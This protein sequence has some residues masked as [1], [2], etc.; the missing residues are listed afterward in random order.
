M[1]DCDTGKSQEGKAVL[2]L[3]TLEVAGFAAPRVDPRPGEQAPGA[4]NVPT[5]VTALT[6][7]FVR[8]EDAAARRASGHRAAAPGLGFQHST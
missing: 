5:V 6:Q 7:V 8:L 2:F 4:D 1:N 3:W